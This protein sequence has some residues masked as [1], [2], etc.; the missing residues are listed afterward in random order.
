MNFKTQVTGENNERPDII[1]MNEKRNE[2]LII[3]AKFWAYL[4][5]NQP[6]EYIKRL[7]N[8]NYNGLKVLTFICPDQRI[9][10]LKSELKRRCDIINFDSLP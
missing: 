10:S 8:S 2:I 3:E 7:Q 1:G 4:T 9:S 6:V 5:E